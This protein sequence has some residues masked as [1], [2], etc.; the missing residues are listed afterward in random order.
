MREITLDYSNVLHFI[1]QQEIARLEKTVNLYH[2]MLHNGTGAGSDFLGW[3]DLPNSYDQEE[4]ERV[5]AAAEEIR[6]KA[7]VFLVV[8]IGGSY[9]GARAAI[10]MLGRCFYNEVPENKRRGPK[11]YFV[12]QNVSSLYINRLLEVIEGQ[13]ICV[14]VISKS[15]TTTESALV[16]RILK[17]YIED[18]YGRVEAG[19]RIYAT[20][21]KSKGSLRLLSGQEGYETFTV[22]DNIGGRYSVL[23]SVGLLPMAVAGIDLNEVMRG[24]QAAANNLSESSLND[25][26]CYQYAAIRNILYNKGKTVEV[27][28]NYEPS[29]FYLGEWFKQLFGESEGKDGKGIFPA[30]LNFTTDLH[31]MGQYM[32]DGR[33][34]LFETVIN[35]ENCYDDIGIKRIKGDMDGLNYLEGKTIDFVNKKAMEGTIAAHVEGGVPNLI[36]NVPDI[37]AYYF[38]YLVYFFEKACAMSGYLLGVNPFDQPGV[39]AYKRNMFKLLGKP[40]G[41]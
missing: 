40:D 21:D 9:L 18:K 38:G 22:P 27:V 6:K 2:Q 7:G 33:R 28:V 5:K 29:L 37:A 14:N 20:T 31:S 30:S 41:E 19:K 24:A 12:G 39:E 3:L 25:N 17:E 23:T 10:E 32:Q 35:I 36:I 1:S 26:I 16:F 4:F 15:G 13:D 34:N 8:G 11:I